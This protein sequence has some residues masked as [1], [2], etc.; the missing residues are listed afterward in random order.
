ML[1]NQRDALDNAQQ[2]NEELAQSSSARIAQLTR[3]HELLRLQE[4]MRQAQLLRLQEQVHISTTL[5]AE[6]RKALQKNNSDQVIA[7][8]RTASELE[9]SLRKQILDA[10]YRLAELQPAWETFIAKI[11]LRRRCA[12]RKSVAVDVW[13][14]FRTDQSLDRMSASNPPT[15]AAVDMAHL[16]IPH[17]ADDL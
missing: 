4:Q 17:I 8:T 5:I 9:V 11:T 16:A 15:G 1:C 12:S 2:R 6:L 10:H 13:K 3:S 14:K 7:N